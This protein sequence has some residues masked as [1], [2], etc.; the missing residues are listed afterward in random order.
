MKVIQFL[1]LLI[2]TVI[3]ASLLPLQVSASQETPQNQDNYTTVLDNGMDLPDGSED[4][5][6]VGALS[7]VLDVILNIFIPREEFWEYHFDRLDGR[8]RDKLPFQTYLDTIG[9]LRDVSG[10]LDGDFSMFDFTYEWSGEMHQLDIGQ[11]IAPHLYRVR[12]VVTGL[13]IILL[14][15]YNYRQVMFL[16][17]G[18]TFN[19]GSNRGSR[20]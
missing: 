4:V 1:R 3:I 16:I 13:Y 5:N 18:T 2:I 11:R 10:A 14:V 9:R 8:L 6:Y 12:I 15:Y 19:Q 7:H 17:R 20:D